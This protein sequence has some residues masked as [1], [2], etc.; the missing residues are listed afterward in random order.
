[1]QSTINRKEPWIAGLMSFFLAGTGH[2]YCGKVGV[3]ILFIIIDLILYFTTAGIGAIIFG[4]IAM[5]TS[6]Q[7]AKDINETIE[8]E[9]IGITQEKE[10]E[11][12]Q[13]KEKEVD[14]AT[15]IENLK[16]S[17]KL[18]INEIYSEEEFLSKKK[19][20]MGDLYSKKLSCSVE[21]FLTE[22]IVLKKQEI[23][24]S[25]EINKIKNLIM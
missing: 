19:S 13:K 14:V 9:D 2:I 25:D 11:L 20:I 24:T 15:F 7:L 8:Q 12:N 6:I 17:H 23:L 22:L 1:M 5:I 4:I 3:G 18:F 21:D 16:N 10:K